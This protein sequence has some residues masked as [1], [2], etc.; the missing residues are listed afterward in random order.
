MGNGSYKVTVGDIVE[1]GVDALAPAP[2]VAGLSVFGRVIAD[3]R[4]RK[5]QAAFERLAEQIAVVGEFS[6]DEARARIEDLLE[7]ADTSATDLL[8]D[9][10]WTF[11]Q[12]LD[13]AAEKYVARLTATYWHRGWTRDGF[14]RRAGRT[15]AEVDLADVACFERL[16]A[17]ALAAVD[18]FARRAGWPTADQPARLDLSTDTVGRLH[19]VVRGGTGV[20]DDSGIFDGP[21]WP[22]LRLIQLQRLAGDLPDGTL[23]ASIDTPFWQGCLMHRLLLLFK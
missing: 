1:A 13:P 3:H 10:F 17:G 7:Q 18:R 21:V 23:R 4:K 22:A 9:Y 11:V 8:F 19:V 6:D 15:L 14:F 16:S 12:T 2:I 5:E 20:G